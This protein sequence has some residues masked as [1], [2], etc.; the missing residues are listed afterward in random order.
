MVL[1]GFRSA[2]HLSMQ[3]SQQWRRLWQQQRIRVVLGTW[4]TRR[5]HHDS[6]QWSFCFDGDIFIAVASVEATVILVV[7]AVA[8]ALVV[9]F[10]TCLLSLQWSLSQ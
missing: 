7:D 9:A 1:Y 4:F 5:K 3:P 2:S 6:R 8:F 10:F